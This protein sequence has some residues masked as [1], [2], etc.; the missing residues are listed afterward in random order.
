M[1]F[2]EHQK[3]GNRKRTDKQSSTVE[4]QDDEHAAISVEDESEQYQLEEAEE[5]LVVKDASNCV[6][7]RRSIKEGK[8]SC[9]TCEKECHDICLEMDLD[10][11]DEEVDYTDSW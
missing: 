9:I 4:S 6:L 8:V 3:S 7:C 1:P 2:W 10:D 11:S 5:E